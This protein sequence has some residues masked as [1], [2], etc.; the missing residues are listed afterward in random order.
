MRTLFS[1]FSDLV[2]GD[3]LTLEGF[4]DNLKQLDDALKRARNEHAEASQEVQYAKD[5]LS[6]KKAQYE[7]A[8][9][10]YK[11]RDKEEKKF[12]Q[13]LQGTVSFLPSNLLG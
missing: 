11:K 6:T 12:L 7:Q 1:E 2:P 8:N 13:S 10:N 5:A 9:E 4:K 3:P